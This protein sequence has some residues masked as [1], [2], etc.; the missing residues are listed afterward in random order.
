[1]YF[2]Y[3]CDSVTTK[4]NCQKATFVSFS[5]YIILND[6]TMKK[7]N[8]DPTQTNCCLFLGMTTVGQSDVMINGSIRDKAAREM[9]C[10]GNEACRYARS[11]SFSLSLPQ[12]PVCP[13]VC[14]PAC[15]V[16]LSSLSF[17]FCISLFYW[18]LSLFLFLFLSLSTP[19]SNSDKGAL[20]LARTLEWII[21]FS[22]VCLKTLFQK[23]CN[24]M[25]K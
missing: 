18:S 5:V 2:S 23:P 15:T 13:S 22:R 12:S 3:D 20:I 24:E 19:R 14:L 10:A 8:Y 4:R 9:N 16:C 11:D 1:M 6:C 25:H 7:R 17:S 21:S